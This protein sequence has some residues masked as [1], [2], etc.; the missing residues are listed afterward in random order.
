MSSSN[1]STTSSLSTSVPSVAK[2][3]HKLATFAAGCF[4]SVQLVYQR[5]IGVLDTKVGYT[6][7]TKSNPTYEDVCAGKTGHAEAVQLS[8][9]PAI[10]SYK[11]LLT[12]FWD[13]HDPTTKNRQGAD[14]GDQYRSAIF[15]HDEEQKRLAIASKDAEEKKLGKTVVTEIVP[16]GP[17]YPAEEYHQRYLEKGGQCSRKGSKDKIRCYG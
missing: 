5:Q 14:I 11:E 10:V 13:K 4:W 8:F 3:E 6:G 7:G 17:F 15:F 2:K 16:A 12:M 9:D 1:L